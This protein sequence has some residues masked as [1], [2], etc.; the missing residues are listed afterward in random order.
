MKHSLNKLFLSLF[1]LAVTI[2]A[3]LRVI[4]GKITE[5]GK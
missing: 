4:V 5:K 3:V 2:N 1:L